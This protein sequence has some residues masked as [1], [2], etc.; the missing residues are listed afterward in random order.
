VAEITGTDTSPAAKQHGAGCGEWCNHCALCGAAI[1]CGARCGEHYG[2]YPE[3]SDS[4]N[5]AAS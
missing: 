5:G 3:P 4:T 1:L 2:V